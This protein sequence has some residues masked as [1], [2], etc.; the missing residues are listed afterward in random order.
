MKVSSNDGGWLEYPCSYQAYHSPNFHFHECDLRQEY[1]CA[2]LNLRGPFLRHLKLTNCLITLPTFQ[3][4][5][6]NCENLEY[7]EIIGVP[8]TLTVCESIFPV[9]IQ[10]RRLTRL[11]TLSLKAHEPTNDHWKYEYNLKPGF[12][13]DLLEHAENLE[14]VF[15]INWSGRTVNYFVNIINKHSRYRKFE[16]FHAMEIRPVIKSVDLIP[17]CVRTAHVNLKKLTISPLTPYQKHDFGIMVIRGILRNHR[18][19]LRELN[20]SHCPVTSAIFRLPLPH[21]RILTAIRTNISSPVLFQHLT[22]KLEKAVFNRNPDSPKGPVRRLLGTFNI[23]CRRLPPSCLSFE[24]YISRRFKELHYSF[25]NSEINDNRGDVYTCKSVIK[26][27]DACTTFDFVSLVLFIMAIILLFIFGLSAMFRAYAPVI[28]MLCVAFLFGWETYDCVN[29][30]RHK[31]SSSNKH[32]RN[33][34]LYYF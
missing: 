31:A 12:L 9:P 2:F 13:Q 21:L 11:K 24:N 25:G 33:E 5:M 15:L 8:R 10:L 28:F 20:L 6:I 1:F 14:R 22:P 29:N 23:I 7:L 27:F 4:I 18:L 16:E 32:R 30:G 19:T 3:S 34:Q 17:L 26:G